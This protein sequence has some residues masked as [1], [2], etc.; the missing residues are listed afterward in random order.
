[1]TEH[2]GAPSSAAERLTA[3]WTRTGV[4]TRPGCPRPVLDAFEARAGARL[5]SGLH[6]L[7]E[8]ANG[9]ERDENGFAFLP[10][11]AYESFAAAAARNPYGWPEPPEPERYYVF[12]DYLD[13][14][15]AYAVRL[16]GTGDADGGPVVPVGMN[17][18]FAVAGSFEEF[19][20][21][22]LDDSARLYPPVA[23]EAP[24]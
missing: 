14:S 2:G 9:T 6:A 7:L 15:W 21:L 5:P 12:C 3:H 8:R 19:V 16:G 24:G 18:M 10:L 13:W 11:E 4:A 20:E 23:Q 17:E 1:M 22:Y